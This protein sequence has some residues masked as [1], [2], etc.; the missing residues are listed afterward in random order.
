MYM[1]IYIYLYICIYIY[2]DVR[3]GKGVA[4]SRVA[5]PS[6]PSANSEAIVNGLF[7]V[8]SAGNGRVSPVEDFEDAQDMAVSRSEFPL[9]PPSRCLGSSRAAISISFEFNVFGSS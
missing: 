5:S 8:V 1:R 6:T 4:A 7:G 9:T 2:A 3:Q